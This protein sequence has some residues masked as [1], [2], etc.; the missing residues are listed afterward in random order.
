M[1]N[2]LFQRFSSFF[3]P[4]MQNEITHKW[5]E[6]KGNNYINSVMA[7]RCNNKENKYESEEGQES[8]E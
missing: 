4:V 5:N 8:Y 1:T 6:V 7:T 3:L 2:F